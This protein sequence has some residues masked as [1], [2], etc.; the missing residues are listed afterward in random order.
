M[1]TAD[2]IAHFG[3]QTALAAALGI[4]QSSV[5]TWGTYPPML[6]QFQIE[7]LTKGRLKVEQQ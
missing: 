2:A 4:H 1:T 7:R 5:S 3:T 6:R